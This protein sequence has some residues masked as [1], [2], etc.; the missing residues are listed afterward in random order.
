MKLAYRH[1]I[2]IYFT[3]KTQ[4]EEQILFRVLCDF[5]YLMNQDASI[6]E[7]TSVIAKLS[8]YKHHTILL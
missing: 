7:I 5:A 3:D 4:S 8:Y 1:S 6:L 2:A